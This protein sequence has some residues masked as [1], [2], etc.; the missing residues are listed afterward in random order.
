MRLETF[1]PPALPLELLRLLG[2]RPSLGL[3]PRGALGLRALGRQF[4]GERTLGLPTLGLASFGLGP[5]LLQPLHLQ[6]VSLGPLSFEPGVG[7]RPSLGTD[8]LIRPRRPRRS[9]P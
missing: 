9:R 8:V 2:G 5:R 7:L 3:D 6:P 1:L 4:L